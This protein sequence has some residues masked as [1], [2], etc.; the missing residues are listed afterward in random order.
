[1]KLST[2]NG[3]ALKMAVDP[4]QPPRVD[5]NQPPR[6]DP[7]QP[8]KVDPNQNPA[9]GIPGVRSLSYNKEAALAGDATNAGNYR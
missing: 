4:N 7:N 6:V 1:M 2:R 3:M 5:P 9:A 8:P